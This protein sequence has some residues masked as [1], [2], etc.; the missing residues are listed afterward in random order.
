ML[1]LL[2]LLLRLLLLLQHDHHLFPIGI[3]F[4]LC[5]E[6]AAKTIVFHSRNGQQHPHRLHISFVFSCSLF[7]C[8][9][10]WSSNWHKYIQRHWMQK[11]GPFSQINF[12]RIFL[13][14]ICLYTTYISCIHLDFIS[15]RK[16]N[17]KKIKNTLPKILI[18][19]EITFTPFRCY[20]FQQIKNNSPFK[21]N[22]DTIESFKTEITFA[23]SLSLFF[24]LRPL[25]KTCW[26]KNCI[27]LQLNRIKWPS[28]RR[29]KSGADFTQEVTNVCFW[30]NTPS[31]YSSSCRSHKCHFWFP[32]LFRF[33]VHQ[34]VTEYQ[35]SRH[36]TLISLIR[37]SAWRKK[38]EK[39][40]EKLKR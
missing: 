37:R 6:N 28:K 35:F 34:C 31:H 22:L 21:S 17:K 14:L 33:Y 1:R 15:P 24:S 36:V 13:Q 3:Y 27:V 4:S 2:P 10:C 18:E 38:E 12:I 39:L 16:K 30:H 20:V 26:K 23:L 5:A 32:S 19:P 25:H 8:F 9:P 29:K 11:W 7:L 40:F